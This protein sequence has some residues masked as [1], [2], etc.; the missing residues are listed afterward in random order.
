MEEKIEK[1]KSLYE[2]LGGKEGVRALAGS[3][4][5]T[6][7]RLPEARRI[8][9]MHP[10]DLQSTCEKFTLFLCGWLGG[11]ALYKE[12]YGPLNLTGLHALLH[13]NEDDRDMWLTCME[14]AL[15]QQD[16]EED[17][18]KL[19]VKRFRVPAEKICNWC[20]QQLSPSPG[21]VTNNVR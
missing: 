3:F 6:M 14:I 1:E 2:L 9:D 11:P 4:Y 12:K 13:I 7:K 15:Q 5:D 16:I 18:Q 17:M 10:E 8:R 19:L 20:Q 21:H